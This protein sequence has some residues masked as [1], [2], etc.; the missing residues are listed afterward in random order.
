[1][2]GEQKR[3]GIASQGLSTSSDL[4]RVKTRSGSRTLTLQDT[5]EIQL[6][7]DRIWVEVSVIARDGRVLG[8]SDLV[9]ASR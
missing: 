7:P 9:L 6:L 1:M 4:W 5:N 2:S 3:P 8:V